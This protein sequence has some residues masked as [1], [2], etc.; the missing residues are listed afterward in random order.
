M[1]I[2]EAPAVPRTPTAIAR[3]VDDVLRTT[4]Q[5]ELFHARYGHPVAK[6]FDLHAGQFPF[7]NLRGTSRDVRSSGQRCCV[8]NAGKG[9]L[10]VLRH[11][12]IR[13][14]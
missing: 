3:G 7:H 2:A 5:Q 6:E 10:H 14:S 8:T 12:S 4:S 13:V 9:T 1:K 11:H